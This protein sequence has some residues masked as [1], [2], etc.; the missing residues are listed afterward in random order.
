MVRIRQTMKG[1][2]ESVEK[3][4]EEFEREENGSGF[5]EKELRRRR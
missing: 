1:V 2:N 3:K 5:A 4:K